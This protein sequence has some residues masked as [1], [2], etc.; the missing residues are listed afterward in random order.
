VSGTADRYERFTAS[1]GYRE[2]RVRKATVIAHLCRGHLTGQ[3]VAADLGAGTGIIRAELERITGNVLYGLEIDHAFI[4]DRARMVRGDVLQAPFADES[5][6]FALLNHV[7]EHVPDPGRL[8]EEAYRVVRPGGT[9]Y[10]TAGNRR[11]IVEPHYRLPFLSWLPRDAAGVYLRWARRGTSYK[12]ITFLNYRPLT[13]L[14]RRA[15]F[16]VRDITE[17]AIEDL[18]Q[19]TWGDTWASVWHALDRL[20][21]NVRQSMLRTWSPQWFF[22]LDRP[23]RPPDLRDPEIPARSDGPA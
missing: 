1:A 7:Y 2:E 3:A 18:I 14:M 11:A 9:V 23:V 13:R 5:L 19:H 15:G 4:V 16:L 12:D 8:F 10:V 22:L 20:P 6:D 17:R 21:R